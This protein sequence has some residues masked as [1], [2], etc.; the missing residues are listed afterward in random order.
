MA[1]DSIVFIHGD[2]PQSR[3]K[4][5]QHASRTVRQREREH[6]MKQSSVRVESSGAL[7][8][9]AAENVHNDDLSI[10]QDISCTHHSRAVISTRALIRKARLEPPADESRD[11]SHPQ[12]LLSGTPTDPFNTLVIDVSHKGMQQLHHYNID[13]P[14]VEFDT[15]PGSPFVPQHIAITSAMECPAAFHAI[16]AMGGVHRAALTGR[17]EPLLVH[18]HHS[19]AL[20]LFRESLEA[21]NSENW[22]TLVQPFIEVIALGEVGGNYS[23]LAI[24]LNGL[25]HLLKRYGGLGKLNHIP[26]TQVLL[27][28]VLHGAGVSW[29]QPGQ[30]LTIDT[31]R[32][33]PEDATIHVQPDLLIEILDYCTLSSRFMNEVTRLI[34]LDPPLLGL[35]RKYFHKSTK[36]AQLV[37]NSATSED[38]FVPGDGFGRKGF[39]RVAILFLIA[40]DILD[41]LRKP[42]QLAVELYLERLH[43][44]YYPNLRLYKFYLMQDGTAVKFTNI[45]KNWDVIRLMQIYKLLDMHH[46]RKIVRSLVDLIQGCLAGEQDNDMD[47]MA[48][49][50]LWTVTTMANN[51]LQS[52]G[53]EDYI[54]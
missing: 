44:L 38:T 17:P 40:W 10:K 35:V 14:S 39:H 30:S 13:M 18:Y 41:L 7:Q 50:D 46:R 33:S 27:C 3:T 45:E 31:P 47:E 28:F 42:N 15:R 43:F 12:T 34:A 52:L 9:D 23:N 36:L 54:P 53:R 8:S 16:V 51:A 20:R 48:A 2:D 49:E 22:T 5:R 37:C 11:A 29:F 6:R 32:Q 19:Q 24:H 26:R 21:V 4:A 25:R 1:V